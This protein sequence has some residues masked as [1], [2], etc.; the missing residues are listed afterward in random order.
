MVLDVEKYLCMKLT[1]AQNIPISPHESCW[2]G[3]IWSLTT[4]SY[5]TYFPSSLC[6]ALFHFAALLSAVST[7]IPCLPSPVSYRGSGFMHLAC[8]VSCAARGPPP[9]PDS[10]ECYYC[11]TGYLVEGLKC[12][13]QAFTWMTEETNIHSPCTVH[14]PGA[15][16]L[17]FH[18]V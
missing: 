5:A 14:C 9:P 3:I 16:K 12:S 10:T 1:E 11:E 8:A 18:R 2:F 15:Q 7:Y 6:R 17:S 4:I 13:S